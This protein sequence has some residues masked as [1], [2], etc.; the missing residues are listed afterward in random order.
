M[1]ILTTEQRHRNMS[2]IRSKDTKPEVW[3]RKLLFAKGFRYRLHAKDIPGK[4]DIWL[5]RYRT[6]IF[7]HGCFWHRHPDCRYATIPKTNA[8]FWQKKFDNNIKRDQIVQQQLKD[9][10]IRCLVIWECTIR[11]MMKDEKTKDQILEQVI[12][13]LASDELYMSL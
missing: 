11:K 10:R 12:R 8:D 6:A 4:P 2:A 5:P 7:V 9:D 3:F 13:F 1:D